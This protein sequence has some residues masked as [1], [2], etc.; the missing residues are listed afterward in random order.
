MERTQTIA[1]KGNGE[2]STTTG[3]R[4]VDSDASAFVPKGDPRITGNFADYSDYALAEM[5]SS[6]AA[7]ALTPER[8]ELLAEVAN[9]LKAKARQEQAVRAEQLS[10][11]PRAVVEDA[12]RD[13]AVGL[14]WLCG[15]YAGLNK[16]ADIPESVTNAIQPIL[17]LGGGELKNIQVG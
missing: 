6:M 16:N 10:T 15:Y 13:L 7:V 3:G 1:D 8:R 9:R 12:V 5:I 17:R 14:N 4:D 2:D 11:I